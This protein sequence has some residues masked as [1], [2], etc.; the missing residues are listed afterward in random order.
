[1][2]ED[3][4]DSSHIVYDEFLECVVRCAV[5]TYEYEFSHETDREDYEVGNKNADA[6]RALVEEGGDGMNKAMASWGLLRK[7][8]AALRKLAKGGDLADVAEHLTARQ[9]IG[10]APDNDVLEGN[11]GI[12][13]WLNTADAKMCRQVFRSRCSTVT[14]GD[15]LGYDVFGLFDWLNG[16]DELITRDEF[17]YYLSRHIPAEFN[18]ATIPAEN[19]EAVFDVISGGDGAVSFVDFEQFLLHGDDFESKASTA[20]VADPEV[21]ELR[22]TFEEFIDGYIKHEF[23]AAVESG[24]QTTAVDDKTN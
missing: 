1:M 21:S 8:R 12:P 23:L 18:D 16:A 2:Q 17:V 19:L 7:N 6:K 4:N 15:K 24:I 14:K 11:V 22:G 3:G 13:E 10:N 9:R 20:G 5:E